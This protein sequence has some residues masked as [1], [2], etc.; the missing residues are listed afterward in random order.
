MPVDGRLDD[1]DGRH[2]LARPGRRPAG[3]AG[4]VALVRAGHQLRV[5]RRELGQRAH[6]AEAVPAQDARR[7]AVAVPGD[8]HELVAQLGDL[9]RA[10]APLGARRA[11]LGAQARRTGRQGRAALL[12]ACRWWRRPSWGEVCHC[13][14]VRHRPV[15][16][17][18]VGRMQ[19]GLSGTEQAGRGAPTSTSTGS[20]PQWGFRG[21]RAAPATSKR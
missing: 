9:L 11:R 15:Q 21:R 3:R 4:R 2:A 8:Q 5:R 6:L 14:G 18:Q 19:A 1:H 13:G 16:R 20:A 10:P 17:R 7:V 12:L